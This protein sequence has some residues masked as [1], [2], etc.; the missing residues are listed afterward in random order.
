MPEFVAE[1]YAQMKAIWARLDGGQRLTIGSVLLAAMVGLGGIVWYAAQPDWVVAFVD[2][3][4]NQ[5]GDAESVLS[6]SG[7]GIKVE[8]DR[9][10]VRTEDLEAARRALAREG[11][12]GAGEAETG[13]LVTNITMDRDSRID[14]LA[15]LNSRRARLA[16][17]KIQGVIEA[18][19]RHIRAKSTPFQAEREQSRAAVILR[20][21]SG[22]DFG[23]IARSAIQLVSATVG[24]APEHV[25]VI[26]AVTKAQF[27]LD[28]KNPSLDDNR[29][30]EQQ[31]RRSEAATAKA[32]AMLDRAYPDK[33]QVMVS[34]VLDP[35]W[36]IRREKAPLQKPIVREERTTK[37]STNDA[38]GTGSGGDPSTTAATAG[39]DSAAATPAVGST[40]QKDTKE[41]VYEPVWSEIDS[42]KLAPEIMFMSVALILD[43]SLDA[44]KEEAI[45]SLIKNTIAWSDTRDQDRFSVLRE[46]LSPPEVLPPVPGPS[47]MLLVEQYGPIVGQVLAVLIVLLFLKRLLKRAA[48]RGGVGSGGSGGATGAASAAQP[49]VDLTPDEARRRMR[50]EIEK[51]IADDPAAIS[52][53]LESW[54]AEHKS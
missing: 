29:F 6:Q 18:D 47:P 9:L 10:L 2:R 21:R 15:E 40:T 37:D 42:G 36:E 19:V 17:L 43:D 44:S 32:Q 28:A 46:K 7:V 27:Q 48:V 3:R 52:E 38:R 20:L 13:S 1:I 31:R 25:S 8:G 22:E 45:K 12:A 4:G 24:V 30:L 35:N 5:I 39:T 23:D 11:V 34:V 53:L 49:A 26:N 50:R 16:V 51:A 41:K 54:L 33:A 14:A